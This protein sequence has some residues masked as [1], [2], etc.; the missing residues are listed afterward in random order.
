MLPQSYQT[1]SV[2]DQFLL[3]AFS[4]VG[5]LERIFIFGSPAAVRLLGQFY[6]SSQRFFTSFT[7]VTQKL[8]RAFSRVYALLPNKTQATYVRVLREISNI[9]NAASPNTV[10]MDFEKAA[11]NAFEQE[12]PSGT[13]TCCFFHF[14][15]N[16]WKKVQNLG[17]QQI[18]CSVFNTCSDDYGIG[19]CTASRC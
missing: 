2:G 7:Q 6:I 17:L 9:T 8:V 15:S 14:S 11:M 12:H 10:L 18:W 13:L 1:T 5:D 19:I 4:G 16:I 3:L